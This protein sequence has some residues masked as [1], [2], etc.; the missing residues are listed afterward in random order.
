MNHEVNCEVNYEVNYEVDAR[1]MRNDHPSSQCRSE[2]SHAMS[3]L[4]RRII[5]SLL[6]TL[7]LF[8]S[9]MECGN[10]L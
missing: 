2:M 10:P 7:E 1:R 4:F 6:R 5:P 8:R 9:R 3:R